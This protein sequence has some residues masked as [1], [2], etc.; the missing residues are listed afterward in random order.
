[1]VDYN[2]LFQY[3]ANQGYAILAVYNRGS[4]GYGKTFFKA[5][6]KKHGEVDLA[7]CIEGK[8]FLKDTDKIDEDRIGII[9]GSYGGFMV[10]AALVF[11]PDSFKIGVDI[12]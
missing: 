11:E 8:K 10:L 4:S 3:L 1:M 12:F 2:P 9:G 7:D 6:D 5:A